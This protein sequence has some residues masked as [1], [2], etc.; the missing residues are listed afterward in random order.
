MPKHLGLAIREARE[1]RGWSLREAGAYMEIDW[2]YL[3]RLEQGERCPSQT[4]AHVLSDTLD[5]DRETTDALLE[6]SSGVG[7][8]WAPTPLNL[9][10][11]ATSEDRRENFR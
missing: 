9:A 7:Q 1:R 11:R 6:H 8:W 5:L 4:I 3:R 2:S 10:P